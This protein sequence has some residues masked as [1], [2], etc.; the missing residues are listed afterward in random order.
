LAV[1][2]AFAAL[3]SM[4]WFLRSRSVAAGMCFAASSV[5]GVL[6]HLLFIQCYAALLCWSVWRVMH[7]DRRWRE[8]GALMS[9]CH[10]V[11][12]LAMLFLYVLHIRFIRPGGGPE[13]ELLEVIVNTAC[14]GW[15]LPLTR[16]SGIIALVLF[17]GATAWGLRLL[18]RSRSDLW[19]FFLVQVI[20]APALFAL[21]APAELLYERYFLLPLAFW[22]LMPAWLLADLL[23]RGVAGRVIALLVII[24]ISAGNLLHTARLLRLGR[25][26]YVDAMTF[27]AERTEGATI[28]IVGDHD[29]RH[30]MIIDFYA[31]DIPGGKQ[32]VYRG[33]YVMPREGAEWYLAHSFDQDADAPATVHD[34]YGNAYE[35]AASYPYAGLSGWSWFVY[36]REGAPWVVRGRPGAGAPAWRSSLR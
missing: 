33:V 10:A 15:G 36:R 21:L 1:F 30:R 6:S 14:L 12:L 22:L 9:R 16:M 20:I 18:W 23:R 27:M 19:V 26:G 25:G 29:F 11:P 17:A 8:L 35:L 34:R 3:L 31:D 24:A 7:L 4:D 32:F 28:L 13:R 2:F 5:L